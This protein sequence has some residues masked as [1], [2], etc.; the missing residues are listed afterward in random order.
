MKL[1]Y[2]TI[3]ALRIHHPAWCLL[4]SDHA[5][6]VVH[7]LHR[8]FIEPNVRTKPAADLA[9]ALED[10]LYT[11]RQQIGPE[12]F[13][14]PALEY[15]N[16][17]AKPEKGWL[18]K[19]YAQSS[20]EPQFDLTPAAEKAIAWLHSLIERQFVGT[21]SRLLTLFELLRQMDEG[22]EA[23]PVK[24][25]AELRKR[26]DEI[27]AEIRR[28]EAGDVALLDDTA[29]KDRFQ[30][31]VQTSRELLA[32]FREVEQNFRRLDRD[33]RE[34]ITLWEGGR[35]T[36]LEEIMG[37]RDAIAESDQGRSFQAFWAFLLSD[38]R[39]KEFSR[40][41]ERVLQLPPVSALNPDP[42]L[43][44]I[45]YDW[46]EAGEHAQ[47]MVAHLSQQ[48]R[49][50]LDDRTRLEHR[51]IIN[52]LHNI[53]TKALTLRAE[54]PKGDFMELAEPAADIRLPME[55]PLYVPTAKHVVTDLRLEQGDAD[56]DAAVLYSQFVVDREQLSANI[57]RELQTSPHISLSELVEKHPLRRGLAEL[58]TYLQ[59][60]SDSFRIT[61]DDEKT[62][63]ISWQNA[64]SDAPT[65]TR[66]ATLKRIIF[67]R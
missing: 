64:D 1:D 66:R 62:E 67:T 10:E 55:R 24:R 43:R 12:T 3:D 47:R 34:R 20:D 54:P 52:L 15:L 7:F 5:P 28:I 18:R 8:S 40:L 41:L 29:L 45:H 17:W 44:R 31:F 57:R 38:S 27:D 65:V 32:D 49:R 51:R 30:Q 58:V 4:R 33:A 9:E 11:L 6:L 16:E 13:P 22:S 23:D 46:L 14:R 50:F 39:Q 59:L 42:R 36:L 26:R 19:F 2:V 35:G 48:L 60:G 53:E 63:T 61:V 21:E 56:L 25:V 37:K